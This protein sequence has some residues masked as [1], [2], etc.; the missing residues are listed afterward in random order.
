MKRVRCTYPVVL[1]YFFIAYMYEE[2]SNK[3]LRKMCEEIFVVS[4]NI[5]IKCLLPR[6]II[7]KYLLHNGI[8]W[9]VKGN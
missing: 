3:K 9:L 8:N 4:R 6:V 1:Y 7:I 2:N 5:S